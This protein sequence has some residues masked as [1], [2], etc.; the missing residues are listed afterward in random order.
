MQ[1]TKHQPVE[2]QEP[3]SI[4]TEAQDFY[5]A[6]Y[7]KKAERLKTEFMSLAL[8]NEVCPH[9]FKDLLWEVGCYEDH[10]T[11]TLEKPSDDWLKKA[12]KLTAEYERR[13]K[14]RFMKRFEERIQMLV[15]LGEEDGMTWEEIVEAFDAKGKRVYDKLRKEEKEYWATPSEDEPEVWQP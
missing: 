13:F 9:P 12:G 8:E 1:K 3:R 15:A 2:D 7:L 10:E 4:F 6:Y 5:F 14:T 11:V